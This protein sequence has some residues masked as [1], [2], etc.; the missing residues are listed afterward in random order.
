[1]NQAL[2]RKTNIIRR[3]LLSLG[4]AFVLVSAITQV[5]GDSPAVPPPWPPPV[6]NIGSTGNVIRGETGAFILFVSP[7]QLDSGIYVNFSVGGTAIPGVDYVPLVSPVC[8][9]C[10]EGPE[11]WCAGGI[12]V[13]TLPDPRLSSFGHAYG[14]VVT[15]EPGLGYVVGEPSSAQ[16]NIIEP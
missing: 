5:H 10:R 8:I 11:A 4:S 15:L 13:K 7:C 2:H 6:I 9:G 3:I 1:M 14:V 12:M 16:M